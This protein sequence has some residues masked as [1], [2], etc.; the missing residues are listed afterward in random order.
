MASPPTILYCH[1][2]Y[3]DALPADVREAVL[4]GLCASGAAFEAVADLCELAARGDP[5]LQRLAAADGL[6]I[7]A[8]HARAVTW[9][10]ARAGAPL[11]ASA[12]LCDMRTESPDTILARLGPGTPA[13]GRTPTPRPAFPEKRPGEWVAWYPVVDYDRCV[14]CRQCVEF[15]LFGTYDLDEARKVRVARPAKCKLNCPACARVC[16]ASA[17]IFPKFTSGGPIAGAPGTLSE[18]AEQGMKTDLARL[19]QGDAYEALRR[20]A[21]RAKAAAE[22]KVAKE[23]A[24]R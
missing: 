10:F 6:R 2:A 20:R 16:P 14:N 23:Q 13:S 17:I 15:C 8:C 22:A 11:P 4:A 18:P 19:G 7:V 3:A 24:D 1:C 21:A 9:L 12:V 5:A